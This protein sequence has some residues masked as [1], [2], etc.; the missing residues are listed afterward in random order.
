MTLQWLPKSTR[1][2]TIRNSPLI[3]ARTKTTPWKTL[4]RS[5][6][7][8]SS[9]LNWSCHRSQA[10]TISPLEVLYSTTTLL[11]HLD[12]HEE[13]LDRHQKRP[14]DRTLNPSHLHPSAF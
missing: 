9:T 11:D 14:S 12:L 1:S 8:C 3:Q 4:T 6:I 13:L 10:H 5:S 7:H 2:T